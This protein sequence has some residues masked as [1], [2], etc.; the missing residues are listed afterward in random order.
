MFHFMHF[1]R[2]IQLYRTL[3][4]KYCLTIAQIKSLLFTGSGQKRNANI[5]NIC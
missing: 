5:D 4:H 2:N 3:N 1:K